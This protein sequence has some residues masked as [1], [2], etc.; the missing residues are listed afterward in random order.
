LSS[1]IDLSNIYSIKFDIR[2]S[3]TGS[4]I[5]ISIHDAGGVTTEITPNI[6]NENVWQLVNFS[7]S[8]VS[9]ENKDAIDQIIITI[10]NADAA[11]TF[12]LDNFGFRINRPLP[13][14]F[15]N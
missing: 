7:L 1:P 13:T 5:K 8:E 15:K 14:F 10:V 12:Y 11:N 3:I 9:N 4:N 2:A 6:I